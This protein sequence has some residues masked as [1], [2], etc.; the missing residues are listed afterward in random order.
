METI[1]CINFCELLTYF[2]N[3]DTSV[4]DIQ[5]KIQELMPNSTC[6]RIYFGSS[7]CSQYFLHLQSDMVKKLIEVG[8]ETHIKLTMVIP[9]FT[10][11][12]LDA[13]KQKIALFSTYF[14]NGIDEVTVNDFG[15]LFYISKRYKINVNIGRLLTKDYRDPRHLAYF[16]QTLKP[17]IFNTFIRQLIDSHKIT[18]I[19]F[20]STHT[21]IDLSEAF[22]QVEVG[23]HSPLCYLTEGHICEFASEPRKLEEKF[24]PN[25]TCRCECLQH[26]I[27]YEISETSHW[28]RLGRTIYFKNEETDIIGINM[29]RLIYFPLDKVVTK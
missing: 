22:S 8:K 10:E 29:I 24:R 21:K 14:G 9:T 20:D 16:Q 19:E 6:Q 25:C 3:E 4:M 7:F 1:A 12:D 17:K 2:V 11:K 28:L 18:G 26:M 13:G 5:T 15:M 27:E 23:I